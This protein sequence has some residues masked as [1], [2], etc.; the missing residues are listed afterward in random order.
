M[1]YFPNP[2]IGGVGEMTEYDN[3]VSLAIDTTNVYHSLYNVL[4][5]AGT[6]DGWTFAAGISGAYTAIADLGVVGGVNQ[7]RLTTA[8]P[9]TLAAGQMLDLTSA[10]VA[11]YLTQAADANH[12][13]NYYV[14]KNI[15][16]NTHI[17]VV[18]AFLGTAS[19]NW[20]K[21]AALVAGASA[22]G[23]YELFWSVTFQPSGTNKLYKFEPRINVTPV[24]TIVAE[25]KPSTADPRAI[26]ASG[27]VVV[28]AGDRITLSCKNKTDTT[29]VTIIHA[30]IRVRRY[31]R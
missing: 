12:N 30:N 26:A 17:D 16:D 9:H 4:L 25:T 2:A 18:S 8:A 13:E 15:P 21:G 23:S 31:L 3:A 10:S 20:R 24:D 19:G 7:V 11:G 6:L 14:I 29:D 5:I 28:A 27:F 22:A 1:S